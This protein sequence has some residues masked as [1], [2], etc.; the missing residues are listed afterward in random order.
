MTTLLPEVWT[1]IGAH[2]PPHHLFKLLCTSKQINSSV[3]NHH[4][5]SRAFGQLI[6]RDFESMEI[7]PCGPS[8]FD[9]LP[10][11]TLDLYDIPRTNGDYHMLMNRFYARMEEMREVY[12]KGAE[13]MV[14]ERNSVCLFGHNMWEPAMWR[15]V[16]TLPPPE[17]NVY[18]FNIVTTWQQNVKLRRDEPFV[19]Q[20]ELTRRQT[21][22]I[23][24]E[25][26][27]AAM[28]GI[29]FNRYLGWRRGQGVAGAENIY[30]IY[31]T[32]RRHLSNHNV[33]PSR[34]WKYWRKIKHTIFEE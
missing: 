17:R 21:L 22:S 25:E 18:F 2:L 1:I 9:V 13:K 33:P 7:H 10:R 6:W 31:S 28:A 19:S 4:Y 29:E 16:F 5:W 32:F 26:R 15:H 30:A 23:I 20:K 8:E 14:A 12:T 34:H 24:E 3:D 27:G 11:V